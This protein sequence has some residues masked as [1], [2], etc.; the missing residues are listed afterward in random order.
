M[1]FEVII[2]RVLPYPQVFQFGLRRKGW[3]IPSYSNN[4]SEAAQCLAQ[5]HKIVAKILQSNHEIRQ[6]NHDIHNE[7]RQSNNE[8]SIQLQELIMRN[9]EGADHRLPNANQPNAEHDN[10]SNY[11]PGALLSP[12]SFTTD[13]DDNASFNS[14]VSSLS[15]RSMGQHPQ[16]PIANL[17]QPN[18]EHDNESDSDYTPGVLLTLGSSTSDFDDNASFKSAVSSFSIHSMGRS[19]SSFLLPSFTEDV[20]NSRAYKRARYFRRRGGDSVMSFDTSAI[21]GDTW[22]ML[23]D[24]SLGG[25]SISEISVLDLPIFLSDLHD[26]TPFQQATATTSKQGRY[27]LKVKWSSRG[28]LHSAIRANNLVALRTLIT[29]GADMEEVD[30]NGDAPLLCFMNTKVAIENLTSNPCPCCGFC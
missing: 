25:L 8:I 15:I 16:P 13:F 23:S 19:M 18:A 29:L 20:L 2:T 10:E 27:R 5:L 3:L 11:A 14:A 1:G 24:M 21:K 4:S 9:D 26:P 22:S 17:N 12:G 6:S 28:R 7:I 30:S